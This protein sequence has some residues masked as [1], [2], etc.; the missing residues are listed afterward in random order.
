MN[1]SPRGFSLIEGL[2]VFFVIAL[3][4]S[5]SALAV[6]TA[7]AKSRDAVRLS[8]VREVQSAL[9]QVFNEVNS[10]PKGEA[11][12]LGDPSIASCLA[13][14][15]FAG[16]CRGSASIILPRVFS[17]IEDGLSGIVS[18]G[19]PLRNA[20]CYTQTE[21]GRSYRIQ[22]ELERDLIPANLAAGVVCASPDGMVAG[23][24]R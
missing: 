14:E 5:L 19:T 1:Y 12:P 11:L 15:G 23:S 8:H 16:D 18:C 13:A 17:T 3:I 9:E 24:C 7:R 4:G 6:N 22:F 10:Y 20:F 2:I 21:N